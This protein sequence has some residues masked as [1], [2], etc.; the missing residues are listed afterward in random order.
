MYVM[1]EAIVIDITHLIEQKKIRRFI[2]DQIN[3]L[4]VSDHIY[5]E[6][7]VS[8]RDGKPQYTG[9]ICDRDSGHLI[10]LC[11]EFLVVK[12]LVNL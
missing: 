10:Q 8:F 12:A 2:S 9:Y 6:C 3:E 11:P 5:E 7:V 1:Q 4:G